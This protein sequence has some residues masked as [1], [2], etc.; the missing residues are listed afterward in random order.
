MSAATA[1]RSCPPVVLYELNEVP[2]RVVDWYIAQRP[3]S[4]LA[5]MLRASQTYTS[6]TKDQGELHPWSTWPTLHRGVYNTTHRLRFINQDRTCAAAYPPIWEVLARKGKRV[7]VFGSLQSYPP[8]ADLDFAF[9]IPDT[10]AP[11]PETVPPRYACF[12]AVNLQQTQADGG[13]PKSV[14]L[15][16][17]LAW[18]LLRL[19]GNGLSL[20]TTAKLAT[21]L[22]NERRSPLFRARRAILQAPLSFDVFHHALL[23]TRP[24]FCTYFTN[25]VAGIM[26][27]YWKYAFPEDF[28]YTPAGASD[29]F[30][31]E[32][33][34]VAL[35][36]ADEQIAALR[37]YADRHGGYLYIASSMGQEAIHW[38]PEQDELRV[39]HLERF[40]RAIGFEASFEPVMA[41]HPNFTVRLNSASD[42]RELAERIKTL[43][44]PR[45]N[46]AFYDFDFEGSTVSFSI[47]CDLDLVKAEALTTAAGKRY[48]LDELGIE[49][50][51]RDV[52]TGYHQPRGIVL[53]YGP[54]VEPRDD[55]RDIESIHVA[56]LIYADLRLPEL[57]IHHPPRAPA[58]AMA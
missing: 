15:D 49:R 2:W 20:R 18:N 44:G 7:G 30:H 23:Q 36:Y 41:M 38:G 34:L 43:L 1:S 32:S 28:D 24:D 16:S 54:D 26:H 39:E 37:A 35:D 31:A 47:G 27:R 50:M 10:F 45:G 53:R 29:I 9:Y 58:P 56:P 17:A 5:A 19:F 4:Q 33:L 48:S 40:V 6:H 12:Q 46:P 8:P 14:R 42:A 21:Q 55:R 57:A 52:G 51:R 13:V 22:V 11:G 25:H 3:A